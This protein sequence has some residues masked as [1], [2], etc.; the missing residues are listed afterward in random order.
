MIWASAMRLSL[1][2]RAKNN[3]VDFQAIKKAGINPAFFM[4]WK[5]MFDKRPVSLYNV[6]KSFGNTPYS[7]YDGFFIVGRK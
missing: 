3:M 4:A 7:L 2:S 6:T 5:D 1:S